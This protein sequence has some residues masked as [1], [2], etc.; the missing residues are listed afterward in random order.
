MAA[1]N[2]LRPRPVPRLALAFSTAA[3][4]IPAVLS[5]LVP[6][7]FG[8]YELFLWLLAIVPAFLLAYYRG[9]RGATT[10]LAAGMALLSVSQ[11]VLAAMGRAVGNWPV[12][13]AVV[14]L[15]VG[16]ALG[17]G[18]VTE[19]LHQARERAEAMAL[20]DEL[21]GLPNRR[22]GRIFLEKEFEAARRGRPLTVVLFD[23]DRF[24]QYNDVHG[25]AAG[26]EALRTFARVLDGTTRKMN[27]SARHGGEEFLSVVSSADVAGALVFTERVRNALALNQPARGQ[28]TVSAGLAAYDPAL[29]TP[30]ELLA[31]ADR[32]L[33]E[34]KRAGRDCVRVAESG[35]PVA[36]NVA[37]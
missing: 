4:L 6:D 23:L 18:L 17:V 7:A 14:A 2:L 20:T 19:L 3:L 11:A 10:A 22:F 21:T 9:W 29:K 32:A 31:A 8:E 36:A 1:A 37:S 5:V 27:V 24:K 12:L 28:L 26:D 13:L 25:H 16:V 33:Y 35:N 30:D 15:F 34:A